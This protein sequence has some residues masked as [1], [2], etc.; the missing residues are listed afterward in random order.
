M[1]ISATDETTAG[2]SPL[3]AKVGALSSQVADLAA[4]LTEV[5]PCNEQRFSVFFL[6]AW[7]LEDTFSFWLVAVV[8][9]MMMMMMMMMMIVFCS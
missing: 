7:N 3:E 4:K 1:L 2:S 5:G 9:A 8:V 6:L